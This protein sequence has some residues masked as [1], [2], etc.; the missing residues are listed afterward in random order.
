MNPE[1]VQRPFEYFRIRPIS[2]ISVTPQI[3]T[4]VLLYILTTLGCY[5]QV[6]STGKM[7]GYAPGVS[8]LFVPIYEEMIFRGLLLRSFESLYRPISAII[9]VSVLFALWVFK[10]ISLLI[11][12]KTHFTWR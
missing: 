4:I 8:M 6:K 12:F 3:L 11:E 5:F 10:V 1:Q 7:Y 9:F 2:K